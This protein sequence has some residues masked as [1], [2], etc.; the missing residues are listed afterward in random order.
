MR[1]GRKRSEKSPQ[2]I[3]VRV[4]FR[5]ATTDNFVWQIHYQ[6][7]TDGA[8]GDEPRKIRDRIDWESIKCCLLAQQRIFTPT[9]SFAFTTIRFDRRFI[10][11]LMF[12][13]SHVTGSRQSVGSRRRVIV[14]LLS[15]PH[16]FVCRFRRRLALILSHDNYSKWKTKFLR[17][18]FALCRNPRGEK[19][20]MKRETSAATS[21]TRLFVC[22][23]RMFHSFCIV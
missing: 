5:C 13:R 3:C 9:P 11:H 21:E 6:R 14:W 10:C 2:M 4:A 22:E 1:A 15:L 20:P 17:L 7:P 16:E 19:S 23:T 12:A 8:D 18:H